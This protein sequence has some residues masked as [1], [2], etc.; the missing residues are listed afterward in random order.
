MRVRFR[1]S[2][3][4]KVRWTSHRDTARMW[5]R[6]FRRVSLPL[7]YTQGFSPRPKVSFGLALPTGAES[8]AEYLDVELD[9]A[10][11][12]LDAALAPRLSAALPIG[13]DVQAAAVVEGAGSLQETVTSC[14]WE[15]EVTG[16]A[17]EELARR[18]EAALAADALV[19]S[20]E[21]K[22]KASEDDVRPGITSCAVDGLRIVCELAAHP[23]TL[24]PSELLLALGP[25]LEAAAVRR[26]HQWIECDGARRDPLP[27]PATDAPHAEEARAS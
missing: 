15:V 26:T 4:G 10:V 27:L 9:P 14:T 6:A 11:T 18:V 19:I 16:V 22:G 24:R 13:L 5:E 1:Y 8:R 2:K 23:R 17:P 3:V 21:R 12:Q 25:D 20:R 7:A